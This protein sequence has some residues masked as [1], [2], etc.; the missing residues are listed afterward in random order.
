MNSA[1]T[2]WCVCVHTRVCVEHA[3]IHTYTQEGLQGW[4]H[5]PGVWVAPVL[6]SGDGFKEPHGLP[7]PRL[8]GTN[9]WHW[10]E[11]WQGPNMEN[12][13]LKQRET[14]FLL[15]YSDFYEY[16]TDHSTSANRKVV[17]DVNG[18]ASCNNDLQI[19]LSFIGT[20]LLLHVHIWQLP[21]HTSI[22]YRQSAVTLFVDT[23][24]HIF[25]V[26]NLYYS[27]WLRVMN[28][29]VNQML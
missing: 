23:F 19:C 16:I 20:T 6:H 15:N 14:L 13:V 22:F 12:K 11:G 18:P 28:I 17:K 29:M 9:H 25:Y 8:T 21:L 2:E 26:I 7:Y 24:V 10:W 5:C 1:F 3:Y 4:C 27:I